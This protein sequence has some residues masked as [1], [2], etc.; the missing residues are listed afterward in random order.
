M[1]RQSGD[2]RSKPSAKKRANNFQAL[3]DLAI[4][5]TADRSLDENLSL[6]VEQTRKLLGTDT[7]YIALRD[8]K[9]GDVYMH[10][11]SG[12][13]TEAFKKMRLPFGSGLGGK[14]AITGRGY[15]VRDY[16]QE[17]QSHVH[18]IVRLEG[19]VS[20]IAVPI[21]MRQINLGVLYAF[22]RTVTQFSEPNLD[23]MFLLGNLAAVEISRKKQEIE[24]QEACT[25]L[26]QKIESRTAELYQANR[27]LKLEIAERKRAMDA[28]AEREFMLRTILSTSPVGIGL[29]ED[30]VII[31]VNEAWMK[32]F[33]FE[34]ESEFIGRSA[35]IVYPS[36]EEYERV[37]NALYEYLKT[38]E[39]ASTDA[40]FKRKDGSLFEG[41]IRMKALQ[42]SDLSKGTIAAISDISDR[43]RAETA[44]T[45]AQENLKLALEGADLGWWDWRI[46]EDK[47]RLDGHSAQIL[48]YPPDGVEPNFLL[49]QELL[50]P[51]DSS[52]ALKALEE[53]LAG[54]TGLFESEHRLRANSGDWKWIMARGRV[55]ERDQDGK[56]L[57]MAGT[58]MDISEHKR[59][60]EAFREGERRFRAIFEGAEDS[61]F[62]KDRMLRYTDVNPAFER[63]VGLPASEI[64]GRTHA[65]LFGTQVSEYI[66]ELELRVLQGETIEE[67]HTQ[68]IH[69]AP[70]AF[71]AT[72]MPLR[73]DS[74]AIVGT[75]T[76][77]HDITDRKRT[78]S[79]PS[80]AE[81]YTSL[82]MRSALSQ[83]TMAAKRAFTILLTG[84]SGSGKDYLAKYI[85]GCSDRATG[86]YF[87][88][89]CAAIAP[90]LAESELF[91]HEKG[92]F[93]GAVSRKR[94]LLELAEGGTL[95]LNEIG[96][97]SPPLQAKLLTF[98][99]TKKF[100]RVG[101]EKE[102]SVNVRIIA[103]TNRD[104]EKEIEEGRFRKDLFYRLNVIR[105]EIPP[106][107]KRFED[108]PVLV[109]QLLSAIR[110]DLQ[111]HDMPLIDP[112]A[113][114]AL[115][116]YDWPGNVRELRNVLERAVIVSQGKALNLGALGFRNAGS[117]PDR[118]KTSFSVSFPT[119]ESMDEI[120]QNLRRFLIEEALRASGGSRQ[121]AAG[122]LGVTRY[123]LKHYMKK[124]GFFDRE[125]D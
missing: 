51:D 41:H 95:L 81:N 111:L 11:L 10:T 25:N 70:M 26:E 93:T 120:T 90:E 86:P 66:T 4:A 115:K 110:M 53:H 42:P 37:G 49:W 108:I 27:D 87:S 69:G 99:D 76:I 74:G 55:V 7:S 62:L 75:L 124:L 122:L 78:E 119:D 102:V 84:E 63:L 29:T 106:L 83:A 5:M 59:A 33:G 14:V 19:V 50:H 114:A 107:R 112:T 80:T 71:L 91:G 88:I 97:L 24:L 92:A 56:P 13:R 17:I 43:K 16:F 2:D 39:A 57:R 31:W 96:E 64:I 3:Y 121:G 52:R 21:Q 1:A 105:I 73:N 101:G 104:L 40:T 22:N 98:L 6:I 12:I 15:I 45:K 117:T 94:G 125:D 82:A 36:P 54:Q 38:G 44:L 85:H 113:M 109:Q 100:N 61:I 20:G 8:E 9:A 123:S 32:L 34:D 77:L 48:G 47:A 79:A 23:T 28:L 58:F 18:D 30:R 35:D 68:A 67:E 60:E 46:P 65:E 103:A 72:R 116:R 118:A 89:N